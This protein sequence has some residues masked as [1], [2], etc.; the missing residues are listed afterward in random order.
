MTDQTTE[1]LIKQLTGMRR[2]VADLEEA[3][4]KVIQGCT[5]AL[6]WLERETSAG[7]VLDFQRWSERAVQ[8]RALSVG[9]ISQLSQ[10]NAA[11]LIR[12][13]QVAQIEAKMRNDELKRVQEQLEQ[14]RDRYSG[15]YDSAP[16]GYF[17]V[18]AESRILEAN[19]T[20]G[21]LLGRSREGLIGTLFSCCVSKRSYNAYY[22]HIER[23][24]A[25]RTK[26]TCEMQLERA[27]DSF[28]ARLDSVAVRDANGYFTRC[29]IVV[30]DI[31]DLKRAEEALRESEEL[32]RITLSSI[33]DTVVITDDNDAFTYICP[34]VHVIFGYSK[35]EVGSFGTV[36][37]LL[38]PDLFDRSEFSRREEI[39]NIERTIT[40][41]AGAEHVLLINV[42]RVSI[43]GGTT[44]FRRRDITDLRRAE[45]GFHASG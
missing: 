45:E 36:S 11:R 20:A 4:Q 35:E 19:T 30:D 41:K 3:L 27:D 44:L 40:D 10:E 31:T 22:E 42:K 39:P 13:L 32:H 21:H 9:D 5:S 43:K 15:L 38:G 34:N 7:K 23:V 6:G 1:Q 2:R 29:R 18:N 28:P 24:F 8:L 16:V 33:S 17:T 26:Q 37:R 12:E 14:S 25:T